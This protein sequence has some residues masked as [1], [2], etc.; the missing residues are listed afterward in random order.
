MYVHRFSV[1][2]DF[3]AKP[4]TAQLDGKHGWL[5]SDKT[6]ADLKHDLTKSIES[7]FEH[8]WIG[9]SKKRTSLRVWFG[10]DKSAWRVV[11][12]VDFVGLI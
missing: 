4:I 7:I 1:Y 6:A 2:Y 10:A 5:N 12:I 9:N 11:D 8:V 3:R